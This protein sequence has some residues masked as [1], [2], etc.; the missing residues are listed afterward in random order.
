MPRSGDGV[1][2][3]IPNITAVPG[4]T[5]ESADWNNYRADLRDNEFNSPRPITAGGTG[6]TN[7]ADALD[8]LGGVGQSNI[9]DAYPIGDFYETVR[10]LD[11]KWL[12]RDG[13]IYD[14]ADYPDL[15]ALLPDLDEGVI[16][17]NVSAGS[18]GD[19]YSVTQGPDR[20]VALARSGANGTITASVSGGPWEVVT[21][22][23][24]FSSAAINYGG[25]IYVA[26][27]GNG[28]YSKSTDGVVWST[29]VTLAGTSPGIT[30]M[31]YGAGVFVITGT[32]NSNKAI[33]TSPDGSTWTER[34]SGSLGAGVLNGVNYA[35]SQ[36]FAFGSAGQIVT[37]PTGTTWTSQVSGVSTTLYAGAYFS[38][39][40]V[41]VGDTGTIITSSTG[42][43]WTPR[44]SGTTEILYSVAGNSLG[45]ITV[46]GNGTA[47][48]SDASGITWISAPTGSSSALRD[49]LIDDSQANRYI[50]V[51]SPSF[52][53]Y[54][55]RASSDQFQV[56]SDDPAYGWIK[57]LDELP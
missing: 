22:L 54:G 55:L 37:S 19:F 50:V 34:L 30:G 51:G 25:G 23:T 39:R 49:V 29:P 42:T 13:N 52:H 46:G 48:I 4:Q 1:W 28:K 44:V 8:N 20:F 14:I 53:L 31:A 10:T 6:A 45:F 24:T 18:S 9:L 33:W 32:L 43:G 2:Y 11:A 3:D 56:P 57:A 12:R 47:R 21:T 27:D 26:V 5:I 41:V 16:W 38:G 35:N 17:T 7:A 40:Y 15:A 36:F